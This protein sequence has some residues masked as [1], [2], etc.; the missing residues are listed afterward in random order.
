VNSQG[1]IRE[2]DNKDAHERDGSLDVD[3]IIIPSSRMNNLKQV[4]KYKAPT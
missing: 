4:F 3:D 1:G 2:E